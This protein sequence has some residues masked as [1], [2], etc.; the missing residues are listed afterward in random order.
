MNGGRI[1]KSRRPDG[2]RREAIT[3]GRAVP[4]I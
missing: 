2:D 1:A 3:S 4:S